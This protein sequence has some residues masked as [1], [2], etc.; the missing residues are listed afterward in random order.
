VQ[1]TRRLL[2]FAELIVPVGATVE[3]TGY[4]AS[5]LGDYFGAGER[6]INGIYL[7]N[8]HALV[9][10]QVIV[11]KQL[12]RIISPPTK[13]SIKQA[14]DYLARLQAKRTAADAAWQKQNELEQQAA[15]Y[16]NK[17]AGKLRK[18]GFS[19]KSP[20]TYRLVTSDK[21]MRVV[22]TKLTELLKTDGYTPVP[23]SRGIVNW[24]SESLPKLFTSAYQQPKD[25]KWLVIVQTGFF[26]KADK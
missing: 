14:N 1:L 20:D 26:R 21:T 16:A 12:L 8:K 4:P 6:K 17:L 24:Q 25:N 13:A 22:V 15:I 23:Q 9:K 10:R 19:F 11:I 7:D 2:I 3:F 18:L 5:D